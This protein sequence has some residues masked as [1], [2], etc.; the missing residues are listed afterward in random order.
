MAKTPLA[1]L[2]KRL[3]QENRLL[4]SL[5]RHKSG[6]IYRIIDTSLWEEDLSIVVTYC[7]VNDLS[8]VRFTRPAVVFMTSC[9]PL[10]SA[11]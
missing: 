4:G 11:A 10:E 3:H 1:E 9:R 2:A 8:G 5:W 7:P 6:D